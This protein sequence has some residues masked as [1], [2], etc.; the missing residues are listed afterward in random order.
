MYPASQQL[1]QQQSSKNCYSVIRILNFNTQQPL[2]IKIQ[3]G[4]NV[5]IWILDTQILNKFVE[6]KEFE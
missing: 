6:Q 3:L 5:E 4:L 2:A 1:Q